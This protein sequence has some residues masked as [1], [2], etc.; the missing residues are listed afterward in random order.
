MNVGSFWLFRMSYTTISNHSQIILSISFC[1]FLNESVIVP[2]QRDLFY[3]AYIT[4]DDDATVATLEN[5]DS[6]EWIDF[7]DIVE[8]RLI[9]DLEDALQR[10]DFTFALDR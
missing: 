3:E 4:F 6:P 8:P 10:D 5:Q 2:S 9:K 7:K 1:R